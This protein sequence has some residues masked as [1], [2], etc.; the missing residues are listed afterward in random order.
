[1]SQP[2][3]LEWSV[4][5][6]TVVRMLRSKADVG[7]RL[8]P[9]GEFVAEPTGAAGGRFESARAFEVVV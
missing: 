8:A 5:S 6:R 2:F 1:M 9:C 4:R 7:P 3:A